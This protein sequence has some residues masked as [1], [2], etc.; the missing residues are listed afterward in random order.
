MKTV[1]LDILPALHRSKHS[2]GREE[3]FISIVLSFVRRWELSLF[4]HGTTS[5]V[6]SLAWVEERSD[7]SPKL[8]LFTVRDHYVVFW[9][10][11]TFLN[12]F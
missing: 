6:N 1:S 10:T 7:A 2:E 12:T 11:I 8:L 4:R 9:Y 3:S 5:K